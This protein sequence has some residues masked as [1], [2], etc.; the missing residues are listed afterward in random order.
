MHLREDKAR[1]QEESVKHMQRINM[2]SEQALNKWGRA[3]IAQKELMK[4]SAMNS[5]KAK[6]VAF[7]MEKQEK[8]LKRMSETVMSTAFGTSV[9]PENLLRVALIGVA[10]SKRGDMFSEI[11]L[12]TTDDALF[13]INSVFNKTLRDGTANAKVYES[14]SQYYAGEKQSANI[15]TGNGSAVTFTGTLS[16]TGIIP[17]TVQIVAGGVQKGVDTGAGTLSGTGIASGTIDYS[18]GAISVTLTTAPASGAVVSVIYNWNS[19]DSNNYD[20]YGELSLA[21]TKERWTVRPMPLGYNFTDMTQL[22]FETTGLGS[23]SEMVEKAIGD[24]HAI[25]RD[26]RAISLAN[27]VASGN[28]VTHFN[29]DFASEGWVNGKD[30]AQFELNKTFANMNAELYNDIHRGMFNN[31]ICAPKALAY[32]STLSNFTEASGDFYSGTRLAGKLGGDKDVFVTPADANILADNEIL[33]TY[34]NPDQELDTALLFGTL[35][36]INADLR[37]PQ[38]YTVGNTARVEGEK[39]INTK[40]VRKLVLDNL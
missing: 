26:N 13:Y 8:A 25:Q 6:K 30:Y 37:Y 2:L 35:T 4:L 12:E 3:D 40:M 7:M 11:Q 1:I 9:R 20:Q 16:P 19:E 15:G 28:T 21:L 39:V 17:Y 36:E 29:T 34:K 38:M 22:M 27:R 23:F 5:N 32:L 33:L 24:A 10:N 14:N 31:L 18:T